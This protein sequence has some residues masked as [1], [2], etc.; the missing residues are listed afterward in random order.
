VRDALLLLGRMRPDPHDSADVFRQALRTLQLEPPADL[1]PRPALPAPFGTP[2]QMLAAV[3][4]SSALT[5]P[6]RPSTTGAVPERETR[7]TRQRTSDED[8]DAADADAAAAFFAA[9]PDVGEAFRAFR[10]GEA[11]APPAAG[12]GLAAQLAVRRG[13]WTRVT[14][15]LLWHSSLQ[16]VFRDR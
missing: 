8:R 15:G 9:R 16:P 5:T 12:P 10:A 11:P 3:T 6:N 13:A 4:T 2:L 14:L 1:P 7:R